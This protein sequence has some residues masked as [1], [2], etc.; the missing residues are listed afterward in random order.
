MQTKLH[1]TACKFCSKVWK[2]FAYGWVIK[3][4]VCSEVST[5]Y[6]CKDFRTLGRVERAFWSSYKRSNKKYMKQ[7]NSLKNACLC[8]WPWVTVQFMPTL[9]KTLK[10][11]CTRLAKSK[12]D[13]IN[14]RSGSLLW[15]YYFLKNYLASNSF[16]FANGSAKKT[17][18]SCSSAIVGGV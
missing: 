2:T 9:V 14:S 17:D 1:G 3:Q 11:P 7:G 5:Q 13:I 6:V 4:V 12:T 16:R 10:F 15:M 18:S 8:A